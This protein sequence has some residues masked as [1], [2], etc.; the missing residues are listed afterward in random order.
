MLAYSRNWLIWMRYLAKLAGNAVTGYNGSVNRLL[1]CSVW[2]KL[3]L[4]D[5]LKPFRGQRGGNHNRRITVKH[6]ECIEPLARRKFLYFSGQRGINRSN[7]LNIQVAS[8]S[9]TTT[10]ISTEE[11]HS[12]KRSWAKMFPQFCLLNARSLPTNGRTLN[13]HINTLY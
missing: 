11:K 6:I 13:S 3:E 10:T 4:L 8:S 7:V 12:N 5:L 1:S 9:T 2:K